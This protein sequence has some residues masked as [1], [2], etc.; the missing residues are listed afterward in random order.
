MLYWVGWGLCKLILTIFGRLESTGSQNVPRKGGVILAPNHVSYADP[1][2]AG[3]GFSHRNVHFMA[4][5][6]LFR[7]PVLGFLI[8][9]VGA[10]PVRQ[11]TADRAALRKALDYLQQGEIVCVFPEGT[12]SLDGKLLP[13]QPGIGMLA[14]K[15]RAPVVPVA[16][17]GT[18][19]LLPPHSAFFH[20]ARVRVAYGKPLTFEDLYERGMEREAVEQVGQRVMS[21]IAELLPQEGMGDRG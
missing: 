6:E 18:E 12:R 7:V 4:K 16:I 21:A 11:N 14:L 1:P 17:V 20:F 8:K 9:H 3:C 15:S 13:A 10:F 5:S 19:K 2:T